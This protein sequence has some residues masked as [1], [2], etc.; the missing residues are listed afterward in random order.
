MKS[1][2]RLLIAALS[3]LVVTGVVVIVALSL[4]V[5]EWQDFAMAVIVGL[6][7]GIPAGLWTERRI[8]RNDPFWPP[9]QA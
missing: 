2:L 6:V 5:V 7:L 1:P 4:G 9:R 3:A 8:K